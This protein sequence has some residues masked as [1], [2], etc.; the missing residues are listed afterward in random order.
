VTAQSERFEGLC[1]E[2]AD[3]LTYLKVRELTQAEACAVMGIAIRA[4]ISD[5]ATLRAFIRTLSAGLRN[6]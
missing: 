3:L 5:P 2:A 4:L 6:S 1:Y